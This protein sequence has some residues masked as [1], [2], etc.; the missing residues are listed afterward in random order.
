MVTGSQLDIF[1]HYGISAQG[2]ARR[3]R[4]LL[5]REQAVKYILAIDQSTSATKAILFD[6]AGRPVDKASVSHPQ[7]YPRPGWVEHDAEELLANTLKADRA[8]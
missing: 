4:E 7:H 8:R 3:A 2:L 5:A 1:A 6:T